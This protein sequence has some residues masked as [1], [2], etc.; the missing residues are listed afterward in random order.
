MW[1]FKANMHRIRFPASV[2]SIVRPSVS[3][4]EFDTNGLNIWPTEGLS[5]WWPSDMVISLRPTTTKSGKSS[6]A[7]TAVEGG[8]KNDLLYNRFFCRVHANNNS[9]ASKRNDGQA[10]G[11][12]RRGWVATPAAL[13]KNAGVYDHMYRVYGEPKCA[14]DL[15]ADFL[16]IN[17]VRAP[18]NAQFDMRPR[19]YA[20]QFQ[21]Q[22]KCRF[23][24]YDAFSTSASN[25]LGA[26]NT[27]ERTSSS[28]GS[29]SVLTIYKNRRL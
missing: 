16:G 19:R 7:S 23:I 12:R 2:R 17:Y 24:G 3:Y 15:F 10:T 4:M 29:R 18:H 13:M 9:V 11:S 5:S 14:G 20:R 28:A 27:A 6:I 8:R 22:C 1:H 26:R 25:A 21:C